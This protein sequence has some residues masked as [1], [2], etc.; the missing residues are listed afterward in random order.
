MSD[1]EHS[2]SDGA[3][4]QDWEEWEDDESSAVKC[5]FSSDTFPNIDAA[6]DFDKNTNAFNLREWRQAN[7]ASE[8]VTLKVI[9]YIR[10]EV[11]AGRD[12]RP[13][14]TLVSSNTSAPWS[15]DAFLCPVLA[16]DELLLH[17]WA[18]EQPL[19]ETDAEAVNEEDDM[20]AMFED[21]KQLAMTDPALRDLLLAASGGTAGAEMRCNHDISSSDDASESSDGDTAAKA[22]AF[23]AAAIDATYFESYSFFDIHR[24]MLSDRV[25]TIAYR[26]A[27]E[28]NPSLLKGATVLDV[29][30]GTGVLSMFAARGGAEKVF[31]VD[32]SPEIALVARKIC[33]ANGYGG[34]VGLENKI[35]VISSKIEALDKLPT[36]DDGSDIKDTSEDKKVDVLVSEW[37]GYALLF[38][39]MLDSVLI[40]RDKYLKPGG[41]ILPDIANIH[42]AAADAGAGGLDFW[43][44]VY[45]FNMSTVGDSLRQAALREAVV[46]V[47]HPQ[48]LMSESQ[49]LV[50]LDLAT[51]KRS[52]QDFTSEFILKSLAGPRTCA[53]I[54]LWFDALFSQRYCKEAPQE[55]PTGPYGTPTHWAQTVLEL[56][57]PVEMAPRAAGVSGAA[58]ALKGRL[59]M[60]RR[61]ERH[62]TLDI[63][64]E[65]A[66]VM[67]D[68]SVGETRV[69]LFSMGVGANK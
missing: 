30:C 35:T 26:D 8:Y 62:R 57:V 7:E 68:G 16:N 25:R 12:P 64:L 39:S 45:G 40:A 23:N 65:Y 2:L 1:S 55:L 27:L 19:L 22:A 41:A 43:Q 49:Q 29:G 33:A 14:L 9:N 21:M 13:L 61:S 66:P 51:M 28:N 63:S 44:D 34:E 48:H 67:A 32:G 10:T 3:S 20:A 18:A 47:V 6:L 69:Q 31:A 17:D 15:D 37:M 50:S 4:Q 38:E 60:A 56:P 36:G 5:L 46:R 53:G 58:V 54:V 11:A 42:I 52:D 59:S 24:D